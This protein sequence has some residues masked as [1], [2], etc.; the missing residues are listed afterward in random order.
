[1]S[2]SLL[3]SATSSSDTAPTASDLPS[4]APRAVRIGFILAAVL[5]T[6]AFAALFLVILTKLPGA[7]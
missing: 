2:D 3:R 4:P 5:G 1:M 6:V 7:F